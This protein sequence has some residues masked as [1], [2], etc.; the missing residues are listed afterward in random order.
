MDSHFFRSRVR[1]H[2]INT[3]N[4]LLRVKKINVTCIMYYAVNRWSK[5]HVMST[6][7]LVIT[8]IGCITEKL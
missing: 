8:I 2:K 1:N 5:K 6:G 3:I 4:F 7:Y